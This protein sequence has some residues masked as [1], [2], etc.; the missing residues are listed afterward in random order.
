MA[1]ARQPEFREIQ[2][3]TTEAEAEMSA[4]EFAEC[5]QDLMEIDPV[6]VLR[7]VIK[8]SPQGFTDSV[9]KSFGLSEEQIEE[10]LR[11]KKN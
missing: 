5:V 2:D 10:L 6:Q 3:D 8:G 9:M 4:E 11:L 1:G 7:I